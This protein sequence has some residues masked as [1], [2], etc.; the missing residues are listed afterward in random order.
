MLDLSPVRIL[1]ARGAALS[2]GKS[3]LIMAVIN[4]TPDSFFEE[5]RHPGVPD[6]VATASRFV[7]EGAD[8]IDVGGEST[9]PQAVPVDEAE[10]MRRVMPVIE[11]LARRVT[12]P[13]RLAG[14]SPRT[15]TGRS[16]QER[17][18]FTR[19][20][21]RRHAPP[22]ARRSAR[23]ARS[24]SSSSGAGTVPVAHA[25]RRSARLGLRAKAGPWR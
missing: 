5:S 21:M 11:E 6:A 20:R 17:R 12:T 14:P 2:L 22:A 1:D 25:R 13:T 9:R 4:V 18:T 24:S 7:T 16:R 19:L 10:E 23:R 3:P 15:K 8:I